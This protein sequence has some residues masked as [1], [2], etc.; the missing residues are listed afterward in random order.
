MRFLSIHHECAHANHMHSSV[1]WIPDISRSYPPLRWA[2]ARHTNF[3][4]YNF[5]KDNEHNA[6]EC[7]THSQCTT[8]GKYNSHA[9]FKM[10]FRICIF[11]E[12]FLYSGPKEHVKHF[13]SSICNVLCRYIFFLLRFKCYM[14]ILSFKKVQDQRSDE[15]LVNQFLPILFH[16]FSLLFSCS[17]YG[18]QKSTMFQYT[19]PCYTANRISFYVNRDVN[20][21]AVNKIKLL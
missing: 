7:W 4:Y 20:V 6:K 2:R 15:H 10:P 12:S 18:L 5:T 8:K 21:H 14:V 19:V 1:Q 17:I 3:L 13:T 11:P 16:L 9:L